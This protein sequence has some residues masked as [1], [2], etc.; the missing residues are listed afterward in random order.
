MPSVEQFFGAMAQKDY[1]LA[2]RIWGASTKENR[3]V[4]RVTMMQSE[5]LRK[6]LTTTSKVL[7]QRRAP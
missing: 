2:A 5:E 4:I 6:F 7:T 3:S 1:A